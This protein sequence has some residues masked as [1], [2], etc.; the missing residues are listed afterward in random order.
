MLEHLTTEARNPAS[1]DL[2]GLSA[3]EIVRLI[4]SEDA[5]VATA[6]AEQAEV[7]AQAI[8][9]IAG[10]LERGGRLIYVGAGTSGRLGVLDAVEC[11]P[12]FNTSPGQVVGV[13]AGGHAALTTSVEGA[14]D[15]PELAA[16]DLKNIRLTDGDVVVG[17]ATSG[18]TPY[19]IGS[20]EYAERVGAFTIGIVCNRDSEIAKRCRLC[21]APVVGP[22][23]VSG[24]TR[25]KAGTATK[26]VLNM[27]STGSMIR[28]GKTFGNLMVD[29]RASNTKLADRARRI[30][31]FV[32]NLSDKESERLLHEAGG[33]VK[34]A[35]VM[36]HY[37]GSSAAEARQRLSAAHGHL[38]KALGDGVNNKEPAH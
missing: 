8:D 14:E 12:T 13:I 17:I 37:T 25:L 23:V 22:E 5:K 30:V 7:I 28:L 36:S 9:V 34:T 26:M 10:R 21:I 29:L 35:I 3:L 15:R 6:V 16:E 31:R 20:L 11:P 19:V 2:D 27:L 18:R 24:S 38:R 33:E 4:N 32:T 1:E